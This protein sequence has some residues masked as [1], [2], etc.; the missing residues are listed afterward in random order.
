MTG[1]YVATYA[2][3]DSILTLHTEP[4]T[5][6]VLP[7]ITTLFS[8]PSM[9]QESICGITADFTIYHV[10]VHDKPVPRLT[11]CS[12][13]CLPLAS[14]PR[15]ILPVDPMAWSGSGPWTEHDVLLSVSMEGEL[16]FWI[17]EESTKAHWRCTGKVRTGRSGFTKAMCSSAKKSALGMDFACWIVLY[18]T[19]VSSRS[20]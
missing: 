18:I 5:T 7:G 1:R 13:T 3:S 12:Q 10:L 16:A 14:A 9:S 11:L 4:S 2:A 20:W 8:L 17:P 15:A 6:L 19:L